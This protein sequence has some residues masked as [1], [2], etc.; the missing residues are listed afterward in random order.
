VFCFVLAPYRTKNKYARVELGKSKTVDFEVD[1]AEKYEAE[2][3]EKAD[4]KKEK[5]NLNDLF[6]PDGDS[7]KKPEKTEEKNSG[8]FV[9]F[10]AHSFSCLFFFFLLVLLR[11]LF[12]PLIYL[13]ASSS[14]HFFVFQK[15]RV[16]MNW[17]T[18]RF[19]RI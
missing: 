1:M 18:L 11:R 14:S 5:T 3:A 15:P 17:S 12:I 2:Q 4:P 16:V 6:S 9:L 13:P 7:E 10:L 19:W 8:L